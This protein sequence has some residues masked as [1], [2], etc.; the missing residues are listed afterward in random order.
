MKKGFGNIELALI[1]AA[2]MS[3]AVLYMF[4]MTISTSLSRWQAIKTCFYIAHYM[5]GPPTTPEKGVVTGDSLNFLNGNRFHKLNIFA[6][7]YDAERQA[8]VNSYFQDMT[9]YDPR[10][11][12]YSYPEERYRATALQILS[13]AAGGESGRIKMPRGGTAQ[14]DELY[15]YTL[16]VAIGED[17]NNR[18][19]GYLMVG[20][21]IKK[22]PSEELKSLFCRMVEFTGVQ[23]ED[24]GE[25]CGLG[26]G[27]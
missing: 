25:Q 18:H 13:A 17:E 19:F 8:V 22:E 10:S 24:Y 16:P 12:T 5:A 26:G 3:V 15:I 23:I 27:P 20:A 6:I 14:I 7:L 21:N 11:G 9:Y 4:N 1:L 2:V